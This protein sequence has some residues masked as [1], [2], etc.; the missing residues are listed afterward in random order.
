MYQATELPLPVRLNSHVVTAGVA[1][2]P[3]RPESM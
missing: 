3:M 2:E 1:A